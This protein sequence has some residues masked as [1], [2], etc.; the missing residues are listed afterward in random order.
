MLCQQ[1][2]QVWFLGI[3]HEFICLC[4]WQMHVP[5]ERFKNIPV[6]TLSPTPLSKEAQ[7]LIQNYV[8]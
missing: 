2:V 6:Y 4:V 7:T 1:L 5:T 3:E 8:K